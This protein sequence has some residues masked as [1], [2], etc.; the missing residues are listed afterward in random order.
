MKKIVKSLVI[1]ASVAAVVGVGTVSFAAWTGGEASRST[2]DLQ[3]GSISAVGFDSIQVFN[4]NETSAIG[5]GTTPVAMKPLMP[6]NQNMTSISDKVT[7]YVIKL[8][9]VPGAGDYSNKAIN[10]K[11]EAK[12]EDT[13]GT[14]TKLKIGTAV[15]NFSASSTEVGSGWSDLSTT[16]KSIKSS[17]VSAGAEYVYYIILD[18]DNSTYTAN[19]N[20]YFKVTFTLGSPIAQS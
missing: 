10:V 16:E 17:D 20:K 14:P 13:S 12:S 5:S 7:Y 11:L 2:A 6:Y 1:A 18:S 4:G 15:P 8:K 9:T 19:A 3:G